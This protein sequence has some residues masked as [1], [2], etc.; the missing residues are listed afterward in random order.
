MYFNVCNKIFTQCFQ[1]NKTFYPFFVFFSMICIEDEFGVKT[2]RQR[3]PKGLKKRKLI[4]NKFEVSEYSECEDVDE[5]REDADEE[6]EEKPIV[7][8][9]TG[10]EYF[11]E[12]DEGV[13]INNN[14][15]YID[16]NNI[17]TTSEFHYQ[18]SI[19]WSCRG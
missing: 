11:K 9:K 17:D 5:E 4:T 3:E 16:E 10:Y 14:E 19:L 1:K 8:C 2:K 6:I 12:S 15:V 7:R 18:T 13:F